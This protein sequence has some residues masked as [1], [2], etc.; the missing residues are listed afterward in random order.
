MKNFAFF[1]TRGM[2]LSEWDKIGSIQREIKP[3]VKL[4]EVFDKVYIF[5]YGVNES[6][7]YANFFPGNVEIVSRPKFFMVIAYS[8]LIPFIHYKKLRSTQFLKTNQMDGSWSA[9]I[10]KKHYGGQLIVRCGYEWLQYLERINVSGLKKSIAYYIE[11]FAYKNADK[12]VITSE[13]GKVF[14]KNN[15]HI[16]DSKINLIPNYIDTKRFG[17]L[18]TQKEPGRIVF[19]GRLDP[20]KN[21][22]NLIKGMKGLNASLVIIGEGPL[23]KDLELL[24]K[25]EKV[26][27]EFRGIVSQENLPLELNKSEIFVLL[28]VSEGNPKVL[29]E[30]MSCGMPCLGSNIPSIREI[31]RDGENGILCQ[32]DAESIHLG[33]VKLLENVDLRK[34][35][36][37]N[38]RKTIMDR[39]S[40][41]KIIEKEL[42]LY[43]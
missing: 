31:I 10:A 40:F 27:V 41:E 29:L 13:E 11:S 42:A 35:L 16:E 28:S 12:I 25:S 37:I 19:V 4:A 38:A 30:G 14:I 15:F 24:A 7:R 8:F 1:L 17:L 9:V 34:Q 6:K 22:E 39:F 3:Y 21:L 18:E 5:S 33:L 20:V 23:R 36:G 32:T 43:E 26:R 2:S